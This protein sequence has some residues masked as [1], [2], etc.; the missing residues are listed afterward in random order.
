[1]GNRAWNILLRNVSRT[2]SCSI[3]GWPQIAVRGTA[4]K[5]VASR[6]TDVA[7][8]NLGLVRDRRII[9][10]PGQS[11][12]VTVTGAA[13]T[14]GCV[15]RWTLRLTLPGGD[16][17]VTIREPASSFA[18]CVGGQMR[19]SPFYREDTLKT[20]IR[21]LSGTAIPS[22]FPQVKREDSRHAGRRIS[23]QK[24]PPPFPAGPARSWCSGC[25]P[26]A[27]RAHWPRDGRRCG[28]MSQATQA[29]L[30]RHSQIPRHSV[31]RLRW[32]GRCGQVARRRSLCWPRRRDGQRAG[33]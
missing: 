4:G 7:F 8:S 9:I 32:H 22:P 5:A 30:R 20:A 10:Y 1:M 23:G 31:R 2:S 26:A 29:R 15:T 18:P 14:P 27:A 28:C 13:A 25:V 12:V 11:A 19:L 6:V 24:P 33:R 21:A 17:Q 3:R 16:R